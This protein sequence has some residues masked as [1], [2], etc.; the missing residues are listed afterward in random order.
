MHAYLDA[1]LDPEVQRITLI[2]APAV[3]GLEPD[4]PPS[5]QPGHQGM[6]GF[7][8]AGMDAGAIT[9]LDADCPRPRPQGLDPAGCDGD[10]ALADPTAARRR[11]GA[12]LEA[13]IRGLEAA[14]TLSARGVRMTPHVLGGELGS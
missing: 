13:M 1:A 9:K 12:V 4:G 14:L 11:I 7:V 10:R 6:R 2:D 8:A 3:L 5:E